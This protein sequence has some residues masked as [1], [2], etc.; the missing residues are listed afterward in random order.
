METRLKILTGVG[1]F[2]FL[3]IIVRLFQFQVISG[4]RYYRLGEMNRIRAITIPGSRGRIFDRNGVLLASTRPAFSVLVIPAE[5]DE[6]GIEKLSSIINIPFVE[7]WQRVERNRRLTQPIKIKRDITLDLVAKIE[8]SSSQLAG[9]SVEVEPL[10]YY[11][12]ADTFSHVLGYVNEIR[13]DEMKKDSTY[14]LSNCIGRSGVEAQYENYLR[15]YDGMKFIEVDARG[16]E[17]GQLYEKRPIPTRAGYD[18]YLTLNASVQRLAYQILKGYRQAAIVG[19]D[20]NDGGIICFISKPSFDPNILL[21][22]LPA[23]EWK[24]LV[25]DRAKPFFNR[26]TMSGYP[27]GSTF[28]PCVAL[29]GLENRI[30]NKSTLFH[31]CTGKYPF[32]NRTFKCWTAHG[33]LN[34]IDAISQSC[35]IYFYQTGLRVGLDLITQTA[36]KCGFGMP[37]G[38]DIPEEN[39]GLIPTRTYLGQ[40][41][42]KNRWTKGI[43]LNLGIG[44]GEILV[45]PLQLANF[46]AMIAG[47]GEFFV[48][49]LLKEVVIKDKTIKFYQEQK[50]QIPISPRNIEII[51]QALFYAVER[52]TGAAAKVEEIVIAGKTG[53]AQNPFGEDHAWFVGYAGNPQP[54]VLFCII[55]ENAGKGGAVS[56]PIA[57]EL[58]RRYF[59]LNDSINFKLVQDSI[60]QNPRN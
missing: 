33:R 38:I 12:F 13:E 18:L 27:P 17:V 36:L 43:L 46:Y 55:V 7:I 37:T 22:P 48:P 14:N 56:A 44:Q 53:T 40:R 41:Y 49:H 9:V 5:T 50:Q 8:E 52:G 3:L 39:K 45:T 30:L 6:A 32:G 29:A 26:V 35:N 15:G 31:S 51:K 4:A 2:L 16:Q 23:G 21:G 47:N 20:L 25:N 24:K 19:I 11:P 42:G 10:R 60:I 58:F 34:L 1:S 57:R 54:K 28:K 59:Q